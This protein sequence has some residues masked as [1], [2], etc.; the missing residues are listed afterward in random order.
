MQQ[1]NTVKTQ[2]RV[3]GE[4]LALSKVLRGRIES[5]VI[6]APCSSLP[7]GSSPLNIKEEG[8]AS[9]NAD[10]I[11]AGPGPDCPGIC[12]LPCTAGQMNP[13]S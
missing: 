11:C 1:R 8:C 3:R 7:V 5:L 2:G 6:L 12:L 10:S 13:V 4:L 9:A